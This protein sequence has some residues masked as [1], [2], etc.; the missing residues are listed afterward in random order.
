MMYLSQKQKLALNWWHPSSPY[1]NCHAIICDGAVRSGKTFCMSVSFIL[2]S[3]FRFEKQVFA[4]CSKTIASVRRNVAF[5]LLE[6]LKRMGFQCHYVAS[7]NYL[8]IV[9]GN[10]EHRFYFFGG[11]HEGSSSLIQGMT[12]AGV[13]LDEVALMPRSFVEQAIARC[14]VEG[15]KIWF[16]CNPDNPYHWFYQEWIVKATQKKTFYLHFRMEDNPSLSKQVIERYQMMYSGAFYER[17][18][19]GKWVSVIG[20]VY[21]MF[22]YQRHTFSKVPDCSD[23]YVSCDY[24]TVNPT[25]MGLWGECQGVWYRI[26]EYYYDSRKEQHQKTDEEYYF[27]LKS[28]TQGKQIKAVV[29]DPS[30]ASFMECIRRHHKFTVLPAVNDVLSGIRKVAD[31]LNS[32]QLRIHQSCRDAI[33]EFSLYR[34]AENHKEDKPQKEFDHAMDD[35]R[36]FVSTIVSADHQFFVM[37]AERR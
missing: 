14:S 35:I 22:D 23:Y 36:Y 31:A 37:S 17:F 3:F 30:A 12:L 18:V 6:Q 2:W 32:N 28:L 21:P 15:A 10:K 13:F 25:S 26:R 16:N 33:R 8:Q 4:I 9:C 29:V 27:D 19:L 5:P 24:G 7:K 20:T 1:A 34:W 11:L